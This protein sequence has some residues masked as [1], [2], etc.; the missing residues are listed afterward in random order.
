M[1]YCKLNYTDL[2]IILDEL[3]RFHEELKVDGD[4]V[5]A[6]KD[7]LSMGIT[8][9]YCAFN[10][11]GLC[12]IVGYFKYKTTAYGEFFYVKPEYRN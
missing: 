3:D 7:R 6:G 9:V 5:Q 10:N 11:K 12:G 1:I 4:S 8:K 2:D